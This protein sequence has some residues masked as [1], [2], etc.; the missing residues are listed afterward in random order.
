M[1]L[2]LAQ[3]GLDMGLETGINTLPVLFIFSSPS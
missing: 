3:H 2:A 1:G